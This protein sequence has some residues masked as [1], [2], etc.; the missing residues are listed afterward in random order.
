MTKRETHSSP[1]IKRR[2]SESQGT[3][4]NVKKKEEEKEKGEKDER[5]EKDEVEREE[6]E[7]ETLSVLKDRGRYGKSTVGTVFTQTGE[8]G[9]MNNG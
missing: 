3:K 1:S 9:V 2:K 8:D 4:K 6:K 5:K 7:N